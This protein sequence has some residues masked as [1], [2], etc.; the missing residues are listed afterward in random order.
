VT[1]DGERSADDGSRRISVPLTIGLLT[2]PIVFGWLL[3]RP[4]YANSTR[5]VVLAYAALGPALFLLS[6]LGDRGGF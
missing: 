6:G 5:S 2:M 3:L 4:G 1:V